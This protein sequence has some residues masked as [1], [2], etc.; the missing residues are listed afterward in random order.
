MQWQSS[1][2]SNRAALPE[3]HLWRV[4]IGIR[5]SG[6]V[7]AV[8]GILREPLVA[9]GY[10]VESTVAE[11][12]PLDFRY[13]QPALPLSPQLSPQLR[14]FKSDDTVDP[15]PLAPLLLQPSLNKFS[16]S[17]AGLGTWMDPIKSD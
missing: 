8:L 16:C 13:A 6:L 10:G 15:M 2:H 1:P 9:S 12:G 7:P 17:R 14:A 4:I 3:T 5:S 11:P